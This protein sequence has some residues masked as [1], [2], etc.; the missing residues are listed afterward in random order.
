M[1]RSGEELTGPLGE[2]LIFRKTTRDTGGELLEVEAVYL[3]HSD[4]PPEHLH[5][6]QEERFH[7]VAGEIQVSID[8]RE[9]V[10]ESGQDFVVPVGARH[11]MQNISNTEGRVIWQTRPALKTERFFE[12]MWGLARDGKTNPKGVPNLLQV[13]VIFREYDREFRLA[14]PSRLIQQMV[15][16]LLAP[17]GRAL[18]YRPAYPKYSKTE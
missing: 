11:W 9:S 10:Y 12:T 7:V 4:P 16:G 1:A 2:R 18:G 14:K 6:Y 13:A 5:A 17:L 15:F 8:G 3:A